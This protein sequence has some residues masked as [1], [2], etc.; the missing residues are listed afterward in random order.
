MGVLSHSQDYLLDVKRNEMWMEAKDVTDAGGAQWIIVMTAT[1]FKSCKV[2]EIS[3][4][5]HYGRASSFPTPCINVKA[6]SKP[7]GLLTNDT[8]T[9]H[10]IRTS[11]EWGEKESRYNASFS[12]GVS[13]LFQTWG[14]QQFLRSLLEL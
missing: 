13:C 9:L 10:K 6:W 4:R 1:Y 14:T 7:E 5:Q 3:Q 12:A 8:R 2:R 11:L